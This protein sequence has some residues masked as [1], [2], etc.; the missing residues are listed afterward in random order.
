MEH[1]LRVIVR[2]DID[3]SAAV[4]EVSGCLT[5]DSS[6]SLPH[7]IQKTASMLKGQQITVDLS[8]ARH[9]EREAVSHLRETSHGYECDIRI[10]CPESL[11][12]CPLSEGARR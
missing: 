2:L 7:L 6:H 10:Q 8:S 1:K 12:K 4:L 11:P 3:P 5:A 9:I